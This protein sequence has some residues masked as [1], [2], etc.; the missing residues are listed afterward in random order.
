M[1]P[2]TDATHALA[3]EIVRACRLLHERGL[4]AGIDGNISARTS[5][6]TVLVTPSGVHKGV[7]APEHIVEVTLE[8]TPVAGGKPT[9]ELP[10]HLEI[11]KR[12]PDIQVVVHSHAPTAVAM[13]LVPTLS[14]NG[15]LPELIIALG[16]VPT[17]PYTRPGTDELA[18]RVAQTLGAGKAVLIERHGTVTVGSSTL[19]ALARTEMIEHAAKILWTANAVGKPAPLD[20]AEVQV[21]STLMNQGRVP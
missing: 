7:L 6:G 19:E 8:G 16:H 2:S 17:V 20:A 21:L 13:T 11:L 1:S 18:T 3:T 12:R 10:M 14:L 9:T 5:T 15:V 4:I